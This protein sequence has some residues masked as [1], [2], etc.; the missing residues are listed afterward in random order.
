MSYPWVSLSTEKVNIRDDIYLKGEK[1]NI[2]D[3]IYHDSTGLVWTNLP[4]LKGDT[5]SKGDKGDKGEIGVTGNKGDKGDKGNI[6]SSF[7]NTGGIIASPKIWTGQANTSGGSVTFN[8]TSASFS[9]ITSVSADIVSSDATAN[10]GVWCVVT[11]SSTSSIT[12]TTYNTTST[13]VVILGITVV[14]SIIT[15][16]YTGVKT[17]SII[18]IGQ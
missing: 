7:Y 18:I 17:I 10:Q 3:I 11:S 16:V 2:G 5:G 6:G 14:G 15:S 12:V 4:S 13:G 8:I 1:G 9:S